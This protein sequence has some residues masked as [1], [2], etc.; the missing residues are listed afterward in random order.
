MRNEN[1]HLQK[2]L[3]KDVLTSFNDN[4]LNQE[5]AQMFI[6]RR[7]INKLQ[8]IATIC[9]YSSVNKE[10]TTDAYHTK[11]NSQ[12]HCRVK[13]MDPTKYVLFDFCVIEIR[14]VVFVCVF[15]QRGDLVSKAYV[16]QLVMRITHISQQCGLGGSRHLPKLI[17]KHRRSLYVCSLENWE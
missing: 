9:D 6:H 7:Q 8:S 1:T 13:E 15:Q 16:S 12:K 17:E 10:P 2:Y 5:I 14:W 11:E 4:S 3:Y